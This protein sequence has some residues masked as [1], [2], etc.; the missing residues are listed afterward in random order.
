MRSP[1]IDVIYDDIDL[2]Y[3]ADGTYQV[4]EFIRVKGAGSAGTA[5]PGYCRRRPC[6]TPDETS[7]ALRMWHQADWLR[8]P[9][10]F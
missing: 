1:A 10:T 3:G 6:E 7:T 5:D 2:D 9:G 8:P 4:G